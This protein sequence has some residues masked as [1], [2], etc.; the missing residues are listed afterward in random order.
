LFF[1]Q[2]YSE[3]DCENYITDTIRNLATLFN[4]S[5]P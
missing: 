5:T 1:P 2:V 4:G 3:R